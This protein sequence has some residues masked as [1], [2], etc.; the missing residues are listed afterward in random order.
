MAF[1][2][3]FAIAAF[4]DLDINQIDVKTAFFYRE[5]DQLLF[6]ETPKGYYNNIEGMVYRLNKALYGLKQSPRLWYE[7]LLSFFLEKRGLTRINAD[8]SI[9]TT[10]QGLERPVV[11]TFVDDIKI[12]G[13]KNIGVIAKVMTELTA[14]FKMADM[15][16]ISFY[17]GL[18]VD[19]DR[20]KTTIKLSQPAYIQKV[21]AKYHF[22]KTNPTNTPMKKIALGHNLS[23]EATQAEKKRYQ[24]MTS[25]LIFS[26]VETWPDIAFAIVV[27]ACF[28]KNPSH[29]DTKAVKTILRYMKG[30][31]NRGITYAGKK[32]LLI[33]GYSDSDWAGNRKS[34][35]STFGFIFMLNGGPVS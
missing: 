4:Y 33:E 22:E 25:L 2:V 18:K 3:L 30:S 35:K 10:S 16:P 1:C 9:F 14:T 5:I 19:K 20:Q 27:A 13:P 24:G 7:Q 34:Q 23:T 12:I 8:Y 17:L 32:K 15:G 21:L 28:A 11:S 26:M 6:V 29:V 31:I